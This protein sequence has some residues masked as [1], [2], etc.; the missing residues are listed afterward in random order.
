MDT[1]LNG[2]SRQSCDRFPP[3]HNASATNFMHRS[4]FVVISFW[5]TMSPLV[6]LNG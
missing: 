6:S 4:V 2:R 3:K 5:F 1:D